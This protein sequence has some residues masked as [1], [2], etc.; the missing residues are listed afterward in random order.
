MAAEK[1]LAGP[2][3][4]FH[5]LEPEPDDLN[6]GFLEEANDSRK[7]INFDGIFKNYFN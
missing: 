2:Q 3:R 6:G 5:V 1:A 4:L 7:K